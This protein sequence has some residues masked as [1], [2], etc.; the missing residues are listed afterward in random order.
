MGGDYGALPADAGDETMLEA[1]GSDGSDAGAEAGAIGAGVAV[2]VGAPGA[3]SGVADLLQPASAATDTTR[4]ASIGV[5]CMQ[6][7][8]RFWRG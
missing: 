1:F 6:C 2:A 4:R 7:P 3:G 5:F 8:F